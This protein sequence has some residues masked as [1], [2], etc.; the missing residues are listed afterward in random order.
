MAGRITRRILLVKPPSTHILGTEGKRSGFP[1]GLGYIAAVLEKTNQ[2]EVEILDA[3]IEGINTEIKLAPDLYQFGLSLTEIKTRIENFKP[4]VVGISCLF[5]IQQ[6]AAMSVA[7]IVKEI[8]P[9]IVTVM[10]GAHPSALPEYI[11]QSPQIDYVVQGEAEES[12]LTLLRTLE[13][14]GNLKT[15]DG[16][17]FKENGK[18]VVNPKL[19]FIKNLDSLPAPS[20]HL[21]RFP[22]YTEEG[23]QHG[24]AK[25]FPFAQIITTRGCPAKCIYCAKRVLWGNSYRMRSLSNVFNEI[26]SLVTTYGIK[27]IHLEDDN[28]TVNRKR[29]LDFCRTVKEHKLDLTFITPNGLALWTLDDEVLEAMKEAGF[30]SLA[31]AVES[32]SQSVLCRIK[33]PTK[34]ASIKPLVSKMKS[35]GFYTKGFFMIGFPEETREEINKTIRLA[36]ELDLDSFS[37]F[38]VTPLPGSEIFN[39]CVNKGL[40]DL[41][42]YDFTYNR[43]ASA[44]LQLSKVAPYDLE[45]VRKEAWLKIHYF[46]RSGSV[47]AGADLNQAEKDL[48]DAI[49]LLPKEINLQ[50]WLKKVVEAK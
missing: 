12:F 14:G 49:S 44:N 34:I 46:D 21:T 45:V 10:G 38:I 43:Y 23:R 20:R 42:Q 27:E 5:S 30:Y 41:G 3:T 16:L 13:E 47:K 36:E 15:V 35:L 26:E 28:F 29:V 18:I 32:G 6:N 37:F 25:R 31:I 2:Y 22:M 8:S 9:D 24:V 4:D 17:A 50:K 33:K 48:G 7:N 11:L 19:S 40:L 39:D 1:L